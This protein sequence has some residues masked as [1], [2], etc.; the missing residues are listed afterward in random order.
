MGRDP[1]LWDEPNT[2]MPSRWLANAATEDDGLETPRKTSSLYGPVGVSDYKYTVFNS[3]NR[4]CIGRPLAFL[5]MK[6]VLT[7]ILPKF[8]F[9][10]TGPPDA[11]YKNSLVS[12][13]S[14]G[15]KVNV[16]RR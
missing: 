15:L 1:S 16:E 2:F 4:V 11:A 5:E 7:S 6:L 8:K 3:G 13:L 12:P 9:T 14:A 10:L